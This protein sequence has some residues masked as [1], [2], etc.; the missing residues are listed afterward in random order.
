MKTREFVAGGYRFIEGVFQYSAGVIALDG[1]EIVRVQF[2][3]PVPIADGF[4]SVEKYLSVRLES[5]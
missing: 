1:H 3:R 5:Y 2:R 4:D